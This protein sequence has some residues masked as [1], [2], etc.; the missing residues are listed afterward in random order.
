M[1]TLTRDSLP[2]KLPVLVEMRTYRVCCDTCEGLNRTLLLTGPHDSGSEFEF[3]ALR[4]A[5]RI[6]SNHADMNHGHKTYLYM[7][8]TNTLL[9]TGVHYGEEVRS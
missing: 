1:P 7:D 6:K 5:E 2:I 3:A 8:T 4:Q 9:S